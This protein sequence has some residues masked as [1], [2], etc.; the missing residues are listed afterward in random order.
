MSTNYSPDFKKIASR[1]AS[2]SAAAV[3]TT[4]ATDSANAANVMWDITDVTVGAPP[5]LLFNLITG[6]TAPATA[7][8]NNA[9]QGSFRLA[10]YQNNAPYIAGPA[11]STLAGFMGPGLFSAGVNVLPTRLDAG[12]SVGVANNFAANLSY[13]AYGNYGYVNPNFT[14]TRGFVGLQFDIGGSLH[15]GW[16]EVT[17]NGTGAGT[18]LHSFGYNSTAG[19]NAVTG[20][21]EPSSLLLF[22]I[23][24]A[25]LGMR[26]RR[27]AA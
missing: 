26:R 11:A 9:A 14:N 16:A 3:A 13:P 19:A 7:S 6:A 23:G 8:A 1:L 17:Q 25:G 22:A 4:V 27:T 12:I 2:Y 15:Y 10:S 20:A 18:T 24:A 5:G 21:P